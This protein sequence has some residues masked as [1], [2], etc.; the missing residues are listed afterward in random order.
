MPWFWTCCYPTLFPSGMGDISQP[1]LRYALS[2][3]GKDVRDVRS[4]LGRCI[5]HR[6]NRFV[7]HPSF[8]FHVGNLMQRRQAKSTCCQ[9]VKRNC[10]D[11]DPDI[12]ELCAQSESD[13]KR[14]LQSVHAFTAQL[15]GTD[16][17]WNDVRRHAQAAVSHNIIEGR[18]LP[19][20]FITSS[21]AEFHH[22]ALSRLVA[23]AVAEELV[24]QGRCTNSREVQSQSEF[25]RMNTDS[26]YRR[27]QILRHPHITCRFFELRTEQYIQNVL[28]PVWG[29]RD[30]FVRYEFAEGRGQIHFHGIF[31]RGDRRPHG[32]FQE[33]NADRPTFERDLHDFMRRLGF[34]TCHVSGSRQDWPP[35]EGTMRQPKDPD[36]L[37]RDFETLSGVD[38][39]SFQ[40]HGQTAPTDAQIDFDNKLTLHVCSPGY[41][42]GRS[43]AKRECKWN[44]GKESEV[45]T[46]DDLP[47]MY[48]SR[49]STDTFTLQRDCRNRLHPSMPRNHPRRLCAA[50][51]HWR[52]CGCNMVCAPSPVYAVPANVTRV[53]VGP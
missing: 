50:I 27:K 1:N 41:C 52:L 26:K 4:W 29:V 7:E 18:G 19:S 38:G 34:T 51:D 9:Y 12:S 15:K 14:F 17:Y 44:F 36:V 48:G 16:A 53:S 13:Q 11:G 42:W 43:G 21:C 6:S 45:K 5:N 46:Y 35:P 49:P 3:Q 2:W 47:G 40:R 23:E 28:G 24:S 22:P 32:L 8:V 39:V 20:F 37:R 10:K 33:A 30:Y 25:D 31:W